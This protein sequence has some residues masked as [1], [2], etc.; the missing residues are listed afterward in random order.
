MSEP[1]VPS[2]DD[3]DQV[4][5]LETL[6][7]QAML[8]ADVG[9]LDVLV[10]HD[11]LYIHSS[12]VCDGKQ[13]LLLAI[14]SGALLYHALDRDDIEVRVLGRDAVLLIGRI[15]IRVE[16]SEVP[17]HLTNL[18]SVA[19]VRADDNWQMKFWQSTAVPGA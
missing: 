7:L 4:R 15:E 5:A 9:L 14:E 13:A 1:C 6:R 16:V 3:L 17:R 10:A 2:C 19:W 8:D 12:A 18:F 11:A